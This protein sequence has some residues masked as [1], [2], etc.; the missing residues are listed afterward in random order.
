ML[1]LTG[2]EVSA[3]IEACN[4]AGE[5]GGREPWGR[6]GQSAWKKLI[7]EEGRRALRPPVRLKSGEVLLWEE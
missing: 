4:V 3:L 7:A 2:D 5:H 1:D 6:A